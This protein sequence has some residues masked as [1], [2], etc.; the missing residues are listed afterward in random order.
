MKNKFFK[1]IAIVIWM[2]V[3]LPA[4]VIATDYYISPTGN[5]LNDGLTTMTPWASISKVNSTTFA[6]GDRILFQAGKTFHGN[7]ILDAQDG[8]SAAKP[9]ILSSYFAF[10]GG[11]GS[12]KEWAKINGDN[13]HGIQILGG[14]G[15]KIQ[16]LVVTGS[17]RNIN[18]RGIGILVDAGQD[19]IIDKVEV[20]GFQMAGVMLYGGTINARVTNVY[21]HDNGYVGIGAGYRKKGLNKNIYVGYCRTIHN[22]GVS[23]SSKY[24]GDQSGSGIHLAKVEGGL[25]EYCES[26]DNGGDFYHEGG[27]GPV[28]IWM[29]DCK[30]VI[31]QHC[32]S[33]HNKSRRLSDNHVYAD[34]GGFDFDSGCKSCIIQYVYSYDN[35]GPGFLL[36]AWDTA[37][38]HLL[39][40]NTLRYSISENDGHVNGGAIWIWKSVN[41]HNMQVYNNIF[42]NSEGRSLITAPDVVGSFFFRNN[43]FALRGNGAFFEGMAPNAVFQGNCYWNYNNKG[44]WDGA[45]S[46]EAWRCLGHETV[47]GKPVGINADPL[48]NFS[49]N[50]EKLTDPTKILQLREYILQSGS[51]C[52]NAGLNLS[53]YFQIN[54]G[55]VDFFGTKLPQ[56][57]TYD[58]GIYEKPTQHH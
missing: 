39:E 48:L 57:K 10:T 13:G 40:D 28:G 55:D 49:P 44:N 32:I 43:I 47:N 25:V 35:S 45:T 29:N 9:L 5:D 14:T 26:A 50:G 54:S 46:L 53:K 38:S 34:G 2:L 16:N 31:V 17:G 41:Q 3:F 1:T 8:S 23:D 30:D 33:H 56:D 24:I 6:A 18:N 7:L 11:T 15:I 52:I 51:P 21:A 19:V 20:E 4:S 42:Y 58:I 36:C 22:S 37:K 12:G 27:N